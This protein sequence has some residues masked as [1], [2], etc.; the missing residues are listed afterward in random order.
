VELTVEDESGGSDTSVSM[1][2]ISDAPKEAQQAV[3]E[4]AIGWNMFS[5]SLRLADSGIQQ[6]L[7]TIAGKYDAIWAYDAASEEWYRYNLNS[8]PF[9]NNLSELKTGVGYWINMTE[10]GILMIQGTQPGTTIV[11]EPSW[12]LV[13]YNSQ[14]AKPVAESMSSI[15]GKYNSVWTYDVHAGQWLRYIPNGQSFL[16]DLEFMQPGKGYWIDVKE[17]CLWDVEL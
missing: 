15:A 11:L 8:P 14:T 4:L 17:R 7:S 16:N 5:I 3:I 2:F 9:L 1:A 10:P 12:N 13:G 6:V